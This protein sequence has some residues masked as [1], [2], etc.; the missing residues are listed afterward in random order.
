MDPSRWEHI[1]AVFHGAVDMSAS[2][3]QTF[4]ENA[5]LGDAELLLAVRELLEADANRACLLDRD[6]NHIAGQLL[7]DGASGSLP[8]THVGRYAIKE[9]LGE[10][11]MGVV[12]L[13]ER[14]DLGSRV[15]MKVLR[16]A[17]VS[18]AR[19]ERFAIE[20]RTLAQLNH[21]FIAA[22]YDGDSLPDGTPWFA[23]EYVEGLSL[24][25]Y[26]RTRNSTI[27][28]RL[29]LFR[30]VCAAVQ[31]AHQRLIVHRDLKPSNI[32]VTEGGTVKLLDFG[33][34]K[35]L[36]ALD[37]PGGKAGT[38]VRLMTP[39]YAS[40][41]QIRGDHAG[42]QTDVYALGVIL[43]ELLAGRRRFDLTGLTPAEADA[44]ILEQTAEKPSTVGRISAP[45]RSLGNS[46]WADLDV[47]CLTAM[48]RDP[49]RRYATVD[50]LIRDLDRFAKGHPLE[51]RGDSLGYRADKFLRRNWKSVAALAVAG[52][53]LVGIGTFH[54]ARVS[55]ARDAALAEAARTQ[56]IQRF[57]LNLFEGGD[58]QVAPAADLRVV[59][60]VERGIREARSL[61]ADPVIQAELYQT[62]GTI[63]QKLG[64]YDAADGLLRSALDERRLA[65]GAAHPDTAD[66]LIAL[67]L[68]RVDQAKLDDAERLVQE[69]LASLRRTLPAEHPSIARA[70]AAVGR[71]LRE[72]GL[73][74]Q[75]VPPLEEAV[76][77]YSAAPGAERDLAATLTALANT[78]FYAGRFDVSDSLNR[79]VLEMDRRLYGDGHPNVADDLINLGASQTSRGHHAD[80]GQ[81]YRE[82]LEILE[83]WYGK[84]H[85]ETASAMTILAQALSPQGQFDE[86]SE[87]LRQALATQERVYGKVHPRVAFA[88]NE[89]G[90]VATRRKALDEAE[91]SLKRALDVYS[92]VYKGKH[93][94]V[95]IA[96]ANLAT[97]YLAREEYDRAAQLLNGALEIYA[98][99]LPADHLNVGIAQSKLGRARLRQKRFQ[100]AEG[101]LL[102]AYAILSKQTNPSLVW[103][104]TVREDLAAV[105]RALDQPDK[106]ERFRLEWAKA[107]S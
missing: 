21:P 29:R 2:E 49:Q 105:Y 66:S 3:R 32:L 90:M 98:S 57:M 100:G 35:Q 43:Y 19:R 23:M 42:I 72:R 75:A 16:D 103:L 84:D 47:L 9:R 97:V 8:L 80:A 56:R 93:A 55:A 45:A 63:Q 38:L 51:A 18:P 13:A 7:T 41:E 33:I 40:P 10:G 22:I 94:R 31:H 107:Q 39:A 1:Q 89:L 74:D 34:A 64:N 88:L 65:S 83:G 54:T 78:H 26:C 77:L 36:E 67:G 101:H 46:A 52:S 25:D 62:L 86:A 27:A 12:Y 11:G 82:A 5:C 99:L 17:W 68:L 50:A 28:E 71:V 85:P 15:A 104:Q 58:T 95:G 60:L 81:Y 48:H 14:E 37:P 59:T 20:Q 6:L 73:Y 92:A 53:G 87:L 30:D 79:R 96:M 69:G 24:T 76:R 61:D 70:V 4:L 102:S 44:V 106:A 91:T